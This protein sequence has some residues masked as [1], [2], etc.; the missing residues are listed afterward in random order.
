MRDFQVNLKV[1]QSIAKSNMWSGIKS[2]ISHKS[3]TSSSIKKIKDN[4]GNATSDP[5]EM[6]NILS[7]FYINVASSR[8]KTIPIN[9]KSPLDYLSNRTSNSLFLTPVTPFEV[10]DIIDT[11]DPSKSVG[12]NSIPIK[13][14]KHVECSIS[15][16]LA[17]LINQSFQSG[18]YPD[19]FTIAKV[20]SLFKKGNPEL[21]SN[22][23]PLSLLSICF[24]Y[25][26]SSCT[27]DFIVFLKYIIFFILYIWV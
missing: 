25:F 17:L 10:K 18:I 13:L 11:L 26:K 20:V 3:F 14:L 9:P 1:M 24:R 12:P 22:Y 21:P 16:L 4:N 2:I 5:S 19:K 23:R 6:S 15:P 27:N 8:T 7:N